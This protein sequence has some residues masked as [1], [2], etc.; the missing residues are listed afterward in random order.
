MYNPATKNYD[1]IQVRSLLCTP[2]PSLYW[3]SR[4]TFLRSTLATVRL[5]FALRSHFQVLTRFPF[6]QSGLGSTLGAVSCAGACRRRSVRYCH[7][8]FARKETQITHFAFF[9][10]NVS[11]SSPHGIQRNLIGVGYW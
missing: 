4:G 10:E 11:Y 9:A 5:P 3:H 8:A 7:G 2:G 6:Q 1:N